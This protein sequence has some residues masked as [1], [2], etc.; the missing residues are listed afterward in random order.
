MSQ[1]RLIA[2]VAIS[3]ALTA[4]GTMRPA[5][6]SATFGTL[7]QLGATLPDGRIEEV[8]GARPFVS[9]LAAASAL[10]DRMHIVDTVP[11][12]MVAKSPV[13]VRDIRVIVPDE[14]VVSEANMYVPPG[15]IV[16]REDP[17]GNRHEQVKAIVEEAMRRGI[18]SLDGPI[19]VNITVQVQ[20]FHALSEKARYTT[21]GIHALTFLLGVYNAETGEL[22]TP[23]RQ[24][25]A[26]LDAFGGQQAMIA[27]SRGLTQKVRITNHLA[28]VIRQELTY[29]DGYHTEARGIMRILS[30]I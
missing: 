2:L 20:R 7:A 10:P 24:V 19:E 11:A 25:R 17:I 14:L 30:F 1:F 26:D 5:P 8:P 12:G 27:E 28:E 23:V 4:C 15:D 9:E 22:M 18:T 3:L 21:G 6:R 13:H 16:W 29:P